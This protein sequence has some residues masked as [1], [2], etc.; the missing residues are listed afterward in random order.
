ME[1]TDRRRAQGDRTR[2]EILDAAMAMASTDGLEGLTIGKLATALGM[3]KAGLFAHFGSKEALQLATVDAAREQVIEQVVGVAADAP[4]GLA[5]LGAML[6]AYARHVESDSLP[7]GCFF[8]GAAAEFDSRPGP[9]RDRIAALW[10]EWSEVVATSVRE[11]IERR[12]VARTVDPDQVAFEAMALVQGAAIARQLL[13]DDTTLARAREAL[14]SR[15]VPPPKK[16][17]KKRG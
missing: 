1:A 12:E 7:G 17:K 16:P 10:R 2:R 4:P 5:R 6:D 11:A 8:T 13:D 3:S 9:V 14:K 15:L